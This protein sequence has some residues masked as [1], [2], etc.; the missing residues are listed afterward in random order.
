MNILF[1]TK[2]YRIRPLEPNEI[3]ST[4]EVYKQCEDFLAL[5][6]VAIASKTMVE[7]DL[8][9]SKRH[10]GIYCGI[11]DKNDTQ[12]GVLDFVPQIDKG[13]S[14]L[15]LIMISKPYRDSGSGTEIINGLEQYLRSNYQTSMI[16]SGVQINNEPGISFWKKCGFIIDKEARDMGDGTTA[17]QMKKNI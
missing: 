9:L 16:V 5:G 7:A 1:C 2:N 12:I 10:N 14:D 6:P 17:Y 3:D 8:D 13:I 15:S 4:L 11:W